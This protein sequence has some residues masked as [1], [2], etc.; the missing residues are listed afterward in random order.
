MF[1]YEILQVLA[2]QK[3]MEQ[4]LVNNLEMIHRLAGVWIGDPELQLHLF[5]GPED[6]RMNLQLQRIL[7]VFGNAEHQLHSA[8]RA[9][10]RLIGTNIFVHRANV[11]L[12]RHGGDGC[13]G[14]FGVH[15]GLGAQTER[16][17]MHENELGS[18]T[19][20]PW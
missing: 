1:V 13:S 6:S 16:K 12:R 7:D 8:A 19:N 15:S 9:K 11:V 20:S 3:Q 17:R 4:S 10:T 14:L 5:T 2:H 18:S